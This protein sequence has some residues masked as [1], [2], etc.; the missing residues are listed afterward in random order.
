MLQGVF[1]KNIFTLLLS[2]TYT[3]YAYIYL[4][5]YAVYVYRCICNTYPHLCVLIYAPTQW[6]WVWG[7]SGSWWWTGRPGVLRFIRS[8]RVGHDWVT[9]LNWY[10]HE[11]IMT[12]LIPSQYHRA[13]SGFV[14]FHVCNLFSTSWMQAGCDLWLLSA[15][16]L[17]CILVS[18]VCAVSSP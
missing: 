13:L 7:N 15:S 12:T 8:Q 2:N 1:P 11:I 17:W 6:T 18:P 16:Q 4:C 9:E 5:V 3:T 10:M 14:P